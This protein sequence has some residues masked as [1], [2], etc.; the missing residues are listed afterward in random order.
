MVIPTVQQ[1]Q[2]Q[3]IARFES[4]LNITIPSFGK[5]FL[6]ALATVQAG[7]I[8]I[9]FM[10]IAQVQKNIFVDTCDVETLG[11]FGQVKLG[12]DRFPATQGQY[13]ALVTGEIGAVI[14]AGTTFRAN[15]D[16][17]SPT[18]RFI[19]DNEFILDGTNLITIRAL[20][21]GNESRLQILNQ[22][23]AESPIALV[24]S[25]ITV[26]SEL[27]QPQSAETVENYRNAI[28]Q[29]F[30][31]EPQ[32]GSPADYRLWSLEV[33]GIINAFPF[34]A[35]GQTSR[36]NLYLEADDND[37]IPT[38]TDLNNVRDNIELPTTTR[39][40]RK[41]VTA[42]VNYLPVVPKEIDIEIADFQD[43]DSDIETLI[44]S[45]L[46]SK[47]NAIRPFVGAIDILANK[48]DYFDVN[49]I[50]SI[51]LEAR[52]GSVFGTITFTI[53][54]FSF[55]QYTFENGNIPKLNTVTYV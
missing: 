35:V 2:A 19:L 12:R 29:A 47:L 34:A 20:E 1:L 48:N 26:Q 45:A 5:S 25:I 8:W 40:S 32:G 43:L 52:P 15:D 30:R 17:F 49:S 27:I 6:R 3:Y 37:G 33:Q 38:V 55:S 7:I 42:I 24:N 41:P 46:E 18:K 36:I 28:I 53:D 44:F 39:P 51:I 16:S 54:L 23:T 10:A 9:L 14:P 22:L 13:Q 11:R 4:E 50:I 21:A 31:L